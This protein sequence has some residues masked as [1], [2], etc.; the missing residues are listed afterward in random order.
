[1]VT[2]I[3]YM[4]LQ[5]YMYST[6]N[7]VHLYC[8][9][10]YAAQRIHQLEEGGKLTRRSHFR[11]WYPTT[12]TEMQGFLAIIFN[13]GLIQ[14]P[15]LED[16]W[17]TSWVTEVPFFH[18]VMPRVRFELLFWLFHVSHSSGTVKRIDKVKLFLDSLL[19]RLYTCYYPGCEL[20]VDETMVG[21]RG[22]FAAK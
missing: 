15:Q 7:Y 21:F 8:T 12:I 14:L 3:L 4:H 20:A 11:K 5:M 16:Y 2:Y 18:R 10:R 1:M 17:K 22:R 9:T 19:V 6:Y 13:M